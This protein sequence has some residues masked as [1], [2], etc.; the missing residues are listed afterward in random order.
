MSS[1]EVIHL[2]KMSK[3]RRTALERLDPGPVFTHGMGDEDGRYCW[4]ALS[5]SVYEG[6]LANARW[7]SDRSPGLRILRSYRD[8]TSQKS[9]IIRLRGIKPEELDNFVRNQIVIIGEYWPNGPGEHF[10]GINLVHSDPKRWTQDLV[11]ASKR[12]FS[13]TIK[14]GIFWLELA[15]NLSP[16]A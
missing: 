14:D 6:V 13:L 15:E 16:P 12:V 1:D 7:R 9:I 10:R 5:P 8:L 11:P 3:R 2:S 4:V